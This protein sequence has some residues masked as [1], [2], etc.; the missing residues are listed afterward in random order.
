MPPARPGASGDR[1]N[2]R[3]WPVAGGSS[4]ARCP[5]S[6]STQK[7][8]PSLARCRWRKACRVPIW[9]QRRRG[10]RKEVASRRRIQ[11]SSLSKKRFHAKIS[12]KPCKM[13]LEKSL[14]SSDLEPAETRETKGGGQSPAD[15]AQL[16]VQKAVPRKNLSQALQDA[17]G[18]K[19]AEFWRTRVGHAIQLSPS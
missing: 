10:K 4:S 16:V 1:G 17:A 12:A 9:S 6:G 11:L 2:E 3:R 19:L 8:Q 5:K 13:P 18:E 7:S 14:P 15:P